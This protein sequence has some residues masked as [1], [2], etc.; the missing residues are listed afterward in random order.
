M[1]VQINARAPESEQRSR[2]TSNGAGNLRES[3]QP[4]LVRVSDAASVAIAP[5][6][7]AQADT[8]PDEPKAEQGQRSGFRYGGG[9]E[10]SP[11]VIRGERHG[12]NALVPIA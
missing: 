6:E 12:V 7:G 9:L 1:P 11:R 8:Y 2:R 10:E 5:R 4:G 3:R